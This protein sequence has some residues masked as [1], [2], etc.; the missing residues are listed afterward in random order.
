M[1]GRQ[2]GC[3]SGG[4]P[5]T[6]SAGHLTWRKGVC[7]QAG[8]GLH[9]L[10]NQA[11]GDRA[12]QTA[13]QGHA[14]PRSS[15]FSLLPWVTSPRRRRKPQAVGGMKYTH[16]LRYP[17]GALRTQQAEK[18]GNWGLRTFWLPSLPLAGPFPF[19][20]AGVRRLTDSEGSW[21]WAAPEPCCQAPHKARALHDKWKEGAQEAKR[22]V[23]TTPPAAGHV[24]F[25]TS[26]NRR[27]E[28]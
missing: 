3:R 24:F 2:A 25:Q 27:K 14:L 7:T 18:A 19:A 8:W 10:Q 12:G 13:P 21:G 11:W 23:G 20:G 5:G 6:C 4:A 15:C 17:T 16:C 28:K 22:E 9:C 26:Q 1:S